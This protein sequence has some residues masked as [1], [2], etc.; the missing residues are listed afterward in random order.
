MTDE[1]VHAWFQ[2]QRSPWAT[3]AMLLVT[4][5][6]STPG[7]LAMAAV[8]VVVLWRSG[9][10]HWVPTLLVAIPGAMLL[11]VAVKHLVQRA[12]PVVEQ[13]VLVLESYSFPSGHAAGSAAFY[14]FAAAWLL[15]RMQGARPAAR[16][17]V[18]AGAVAM[19]A[20]VA[21]SRVYL[22]VHYLSDVIAGVLLG[23]L[24]LTVCLAVAARLRA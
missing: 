10:R 22:G 19:T 2:S 12:R 9:D 23:T 17:A 21:L 13:P 7:L 8:L 5:L 3:Q 24:W 15:S 1:L 11:N 14:T 18:V 4:Y 6:H 16:A 20:W